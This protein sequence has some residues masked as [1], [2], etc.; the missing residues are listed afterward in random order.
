MLTTLG[1]ATTCGWSNTNF[2][3][4]EAE[5]SEAVSD[6]AIGVLPTEPPTVGDELEP[7]PDDD[8][9]P[10]G[11]GQPFP[12]TE[13]YELKGL[14]GLWVLQIQFNS[15]TNAEVTY[16]SPVPES[17]Q[18]VQALTVDNLAERHRYCVD[19]VAYLE[20][21]ILQER[22]AAQEATTG[23]LAQSEEYAQVCWEGSRFDGAKGKVVRRSKDEVELLIEGCDYNP[24]F[25]VQRVRF[26]K[27]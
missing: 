3:N 1:E 23:E 4:Q 26:F 5:T 11:G 20:Q 25:P 21:E 10:P 16:T 12:R 13:R 2:T 14:L 24:C 6:T 17:K 9:S 18:Y 15:P 7:S 22:A 19:G 8:P 27:S